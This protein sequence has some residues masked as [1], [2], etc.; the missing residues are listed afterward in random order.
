MDWNRG[1]QRANLMDRYL[2]QFVL[3]KLP[4]IALEQ[5]VG[6]EKNAGKSWDFKATDVSEEDVRV[7]LGDKK[8]SY[9]ELQ[10][11]AMRLGDAGHFDDVVKLIAHIRDTYRKPK[12]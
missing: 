7:A 2:L 1:T 5:A 4:A 12:L 3:G 11:M 10:V 8:C 9:S 6:Y